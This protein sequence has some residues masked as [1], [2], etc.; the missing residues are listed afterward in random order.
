MN[1]IGLSQGIT[2]VDINFIHVLGVYLVATTVSLCCLYWG[3]LYWSRD[4]P[5]EIPILEHPLIKSRQLAPGPF[6]VGEMGNSIFNCS[7]ELFKENEAQR[8]TCT[9]YREATIMSSRDTHL[10]KQTQLQLEDERGPTDRSK[11]SVTSQ[12]RLDA[13]V[14]HIHNGTDL[15]WIVTA[16]FYNSDTCHGKILV[17]C[18]YNSTSWVQYLWKF[19]VCMI[20]TFNPTNWNRVNFTLIL[21]NNITV[22]WFIL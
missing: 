2:Q 6:V 5:W 15:F 13:T 1:L 14:R 21:Y 17:L 12:T 16:K 11:L 3:T 22:R 8:C 7:E 4:Y 18:T 10:I 9:A 19:W 20:N